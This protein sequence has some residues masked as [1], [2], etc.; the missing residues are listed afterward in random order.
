MKNFEFFTVKNNDDSFFVLI[1]E[2]GYS[3]REIYEAARKFPAKENDIVSV[4]YNGFFLYIDK[5][6]SFEDFKEDYLKKL[7][8]KEKEETYIKRLEEVEPADLSSE[9]TT[10]E[11]ALR[12]AEEVFGILYE[13]S[14]EEV[15]ISDNNRGR[16]RNA[17]RHAG[18]AET[19]KI[20][21]KFIK[22]DV[23]I[24]KLLK[25][26]SVAFP[27]EVMGVYLND[28]LPKSKQNFQYNY[29]FS[30]NEYSW[31]HTWL[32]TQKENDNEIEAE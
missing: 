20:Q 28:K 26:K 16:F 29:A 2:E 4:E 7:G 31:V 1:P 18:F 15:K 30:G 13:M 22:D 25:E 10:E 19:A 14:E 6:I 3:L 12:M 11:D 23:P 9:Q 21:P 8:R 32:N 24:G 17:L 5:E 27:V